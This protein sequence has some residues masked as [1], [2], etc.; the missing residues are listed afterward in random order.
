[1]FHV[2]SGKAFSTIP[3]NYFSDYEM[4]NEV[5]RQEPATSLDPE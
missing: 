5:V 4:L 3:P 2:G 1:V